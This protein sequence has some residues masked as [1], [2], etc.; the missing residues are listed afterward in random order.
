MRFIDSNVFIYALYK[1]KR[2]LSERARRMKEEAK[3]I[4]ERVNSGEE[5]LTTVVHLSEV[6]NFLKR[7]MSYQKLQDFLMD[8]LSLDN[9]EVVDVSRE[10]YLAA[11]SMVSEWEMDAND[12]LALLV[13]RD[14]GIEEIYSFDKAFDRFARRLPRIEA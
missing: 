7:S 11:A 8:L 3:R 13:M 6:N 9:L 4:L 14:R 5:V 10:I 2:E 1:P 12:C